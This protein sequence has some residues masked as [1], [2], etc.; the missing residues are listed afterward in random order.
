M[1]MQ[2]CPYCGTKLDKGVRFCKNCGEPVIQVQEHTDEILFNQEA[3]TEAKTPK[4]E[5]VSEDPRTQ[6][7]TVYDGELHKCPNC[8]ET[9]RAFIAF[10]PS[11]GY[12]LRGSTVTSSVQKFYQALK[13]TTSIEQKISMIRNYPIP[14]AKEDIIEFIF[15][16]SS[17]IKGEA[18]KGIF[19]AWVAKYEQA[20]Q[21]AQITLKNDSAF[22]QI[23]EIHEKTEKAIAL[24]K[25]SHTTA[26]ASNVAKS[27]FRMMPNPVFAIIAFFL[28][29]FNLARLFSG[30][31]AGIDIIFDAIILS[32]AYNLTAKKAKNANIT[33]E[34]LEIRENKIK[35]PSAIINGTENNYVVIETMLVQ[36]GFRN[37][38]VVPL[39]NL[40]LGVRNKPG[41]VDRITVNGKELSSYLRKKFDADSSIVITYH[42]MRK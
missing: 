16:A 2:F 18:N 32:V 39:N 26:T 42:S 10:C 14:N 37:V 5:Q 12:E 3:K 9:L 17:N 20:Y 31:F 19:E 27:Y 30:Q 23:E 21:K 1:K 7:K 8:G 36:A 4:E 25:I 15:L 41:T 29:I 22:T 24:E 6:R 28:I 13:R 33:G 40:T 35:V 38:Q 11:C 34:D